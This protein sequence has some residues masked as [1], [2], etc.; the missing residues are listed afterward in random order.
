MWATKKGT[1]TLSHHGLLTWHLIAKEWVMWAEQ[2]KV[3]ALRDAVA[4][5]SEQGHSDTGFH[6]EIIG[7]H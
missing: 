1:P 4:I 3:S 5:W 7:A 2:A 6:S